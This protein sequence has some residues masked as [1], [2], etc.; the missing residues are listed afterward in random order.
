MET[1]ALLTVFTPVYNRKD[2]LTIAYKE[3]CKQTNHR[4]VWLIVDDGSTDG[5]ESLVSSWMNEDQIAIRYYKQEN[6]GKMRAHNYGVK[7]CNTELFVCVDSDDYLVVNAIEQIIQTWNNLLE[8]LPE[9][10][11]SSVAGMVAYRGQSETQTMAGEQFAFEGMEK[12]DGMFFD[13]L[14]AI[15]QKGFFG[16]T[17]LVFRTDV[18]KQYP[19][20]EFLAEKFIPEAVVYD[21]IDQKYEYL[22]LDKVLTICEYQAEGLTNSIRA[23]RRNNPN[24]WLFYYIQKIESY[25]INKKKRNL[26]YYKYLSH[27][28][29]FCRLTGEKI[30]KKVTIS[31]SDIFIASVLALALRMAGKL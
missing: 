18:I 3:L 5:T 2:L 31:K 9:I 6:G 13:T 26:L 29:N 12:K 27:A 24:G 28:L 4:F 19:F 14:S 17:T 10:D 30:E 8:K 22:L 25:S 16:E 15:Y 21:Q 7:L 1:K 20:P 11:F 23:L